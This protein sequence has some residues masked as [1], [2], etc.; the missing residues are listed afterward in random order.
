M[1]ERTN[2]HIQVDVQLPVAYGLND[3]VHHLLPL[4]SRSASHMV[5]VRRHL[6][7]KQTNVCSFGVARSTKTNQRPKYHQRLL[8]GLKIPRA[9]HTVPPLP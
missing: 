4:T 7:N 6:L 8:L 3:C 9:R 1:N 5:G 2:E